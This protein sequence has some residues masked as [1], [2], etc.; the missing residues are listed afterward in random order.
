MNTML[1]LE[2][3]AKLMAAYAATLYFGNP[4]W[5]FFALLLL[6]DLSMI[7]YIIN[8]RAGAILYNIAHHQGLALVIVI[9]GVYLTHPLLILGGCVLFG[10]SAM[11][12]LFGY[13][14]KYTDDFKHTHL[15]WIG[16]DKVQS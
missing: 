15:G 8:P 14:L 5:L 10:H 13:G 11:D 2:N 4:W 7:G 16:K 6:P 1:K 12:R 9:T 3:L